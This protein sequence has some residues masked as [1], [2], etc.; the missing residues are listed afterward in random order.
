MRAAERADVA[1]DRVV[2]AVT[3]GPIP[4]DVARNIEGFTR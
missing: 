1:F 4:G 3:I 2:E